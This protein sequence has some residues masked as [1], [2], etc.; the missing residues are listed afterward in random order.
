MFEYI[1]AYT[2]ADKP[3]GFFKLGLSCIMKLMEG[4]K[5][6]SFLSH[7][8]IAP[9]IRQLMEIIS[10][11]LREKPDEY[12]NYH[13]IITDMMILVM[14]NVQNEPYL[15]E[16]LSSN[17]NDKSSSKASSNQNEKSESNFPPLNILI[18]LLK[19]ANPADKSNHLPKLVATIKTIIQLNNKYVNEIAEPIMRKL[20][21]IYDCLPIMLKTTDSSGNEVFELKEQIMIS[22][23]KGYPKSVEHYLRV[24]DNF[25]Q[26][27]EF[28]D[29]LLFSIKDSK[30]IDHLI[31]NLF[32]Q[33]CVKIQDI[34]L[35]NLNYEKYRTCTQY[36]IVIIHTMRHPKI[37]EIMFNFL[38]GFS[39]EDKSETN[40]SSCIF[41]IHNS[42]TPK[43]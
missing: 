20:S 1:C 7:C 36:L 3:T 8:K 42:Q 2:K 5:S 29:Q 32:N 6:N 40:D 10:I 33:F 39:T 12:N 14:E 19:K 27:I 11:S 17:S 30:L 38:F 37:T 25:I 43:M 21:T 24:Y 13:T 18:F 23:N 41:E 15:L 22:C 26:F 9:G 31:H 35:D 16:L 28:I 4:V 34:L